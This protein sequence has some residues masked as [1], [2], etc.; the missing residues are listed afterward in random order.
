MAYEDFYTTLISAEQLAVAIDRSVVVDCRH[1]LLN[2]DA[3]F[4]AYEEGHIPGAYFVH[5]D[6]DIAGEKTGKN[7]RHPLPTRDDLEGVL[8]RL[9]LNRGQQLVVYDNHGGMYAGR[10]WWMAKWLGHPHVAVLDGGLA[11]WIK[12]GFPQS[13]HSPDHP[14]RGSF[15]LS[16]SLL[17]SVNALQVEA[18]LHSRN[19]QVLDARAAE[20][21]RGETEPIDPVAGHIPG[22]LNRPFQCNLRPDGLF[23]P[24]EVLQAE[25]LAIL[26]D[27][28]A[29]VMVHQ[30]GS[31]VT[32]CHNVLAMEHAGLHGSQLYPGSWSEWSAL[33][34]RP[35]ATGAAPG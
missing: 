34:T 3:G 29:D 28:R 23:K 11:A 30:C 19:L 35:V 17:P 21:Y 26:G 25:F 5:Q 32:A 2:H 33:G 10:L 31:G 8:Q 24:A 20:R 18:N 14:R 7:G 22:A 16:E 9:G 15:T 1:D 4:A 27:K 13:K 6:D 12:M